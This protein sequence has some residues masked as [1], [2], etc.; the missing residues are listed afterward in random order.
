MKVSF[1]QFAAVLAVVA[2]PWGWANGQ[3]TSQE[4]EAASPKGNDVQQ[5]IK[6]L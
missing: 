6:E 5:Q 2:C 1:F 3:E 4:K